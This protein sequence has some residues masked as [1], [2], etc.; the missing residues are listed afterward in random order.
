MLSK[1]HHVVKVV[2]GSSIGL[3]DQGLHLLWLDVGAELNTGITGWGRL[4]GEEGRSLSSEVEDVL[5]GVSGGSVSLWDEG[6]DLLWLDVSVELITTLLA[7]LGVESGPLWGISLKCGDVVSVGFW[8]QS[9]DLLW[10]LVSVEITLGLGKGLVLLS[11]VSGSRV[12]VR[13]LV[14][15]NLLWGGVWVQ[16]GGVSDSLGSGV[17]SDSH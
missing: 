8:D 3:W 2:S 16:W 6:L 11:V 17:F 9:L 12:S 5:T 4:L 1:V 14:I 7:N 15:L 10:L 13:D